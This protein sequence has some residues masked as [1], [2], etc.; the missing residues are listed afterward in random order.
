MTILG[1][2]LGLCRRLGA[3]RPPR[4]QSAK[5][6]RAAIN[7]GQGDVGKANEPVTVGTAADG[8]GLANDGFGHEE[9]GATPSDLAARPDAP[10]LLVRAIVKIAG[11][12]DERPGRRSIELGRLALAQRLVRPL[13]VELTAKRRRSGSVGRQR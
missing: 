3:G 6:A 12:L 7:D 10:D 13:M 8:D 2:G 11:R 5:F 9:Q 4:S 1:I